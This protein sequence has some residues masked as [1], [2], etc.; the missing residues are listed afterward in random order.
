MAAE[1]V[2]TVPDVRLYDELVD[3]VSG[4][5]ILH[6]DMSAP[7]PREHLDVVVPPYLGGPGP[8]VRLAGVTT[9][10]VQGQSIGYDDVA[11]YLPPGHRFANAAGVHEASTA[12]L[13]LAL[14]LASQRGLDE[15]ARAAARGQWTPRWRA[16]LADRTVVLVGAGGVGSAVAA[17]L[18]PFETRIVR[19]ARRAR[20]DEVGQVVG[21]DS[22]EQCLAGADI[23]VLSVPLTDET[24]HLVDARFLS[25]LPDGALLVNVARGR[26]VDTAALL[27]EA[28]L[29]RLRF[30]LD[31]T[32]P[33][34]LPEGHEL[35]SLPNV[36]VTPHVGG[37]SSAMMPRMV[38]LIAEQIAR[39][40][41]GEDPRNV[42][43][44]T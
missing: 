25:R 4:V 26:V 10:L 44:E 20:V 42:V 9:R 30:A 6:W 8:L 39:L 33:E 3:V 32:D 11:A 36:I 35:F 34:P 23:V 29:G 17:R 37:A 40:E 14:I 16:S 28:R 18:A 7:A 5:E 31:V 19:V 12:E 43:L 13:A 27:V 24:E 15:F 2:V 38:R 41:R 21:M 1:L 22:L